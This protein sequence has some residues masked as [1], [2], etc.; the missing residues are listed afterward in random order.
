MFIKSI[1]FLDDENV[2]VE[3]R[4]GSLNGNIEIDYE[5][6]ESQPIEEIEYIIYREVTAEFHHLDNSLQFSNRAREES[7]AALKDWKKGISL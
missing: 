2:C 6:I 5:L 4:V 7:F 1:R 3:F